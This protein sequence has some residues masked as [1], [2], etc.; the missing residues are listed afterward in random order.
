MEA[1]VNVDEIRSLVR[2]ND[3][4]YIEVRLEEGVASDITISGREIDSIS[5]GK[6]GGGNARV[7]I[8]GI[9]GFVY[10][11][12]LSELKEKIESAISQAKTLKGTVD[13][14]VDLAYVKPVEIVDTVNVKKDPDSLSFND[15]VDLLMHYS[16]VALSTDKK[17]VNTMISYREQKKN[18]YFAN[19]EGT[20]VQREMLDLSGFIIPMSS[21]GREI[22]RTLVTFGSNSDFSVA[23][24]LDTAVREKSL[25]AVKLLEAEVPKGGEFPV[26]ADN[27]LGGVFIHEA[28]GHLSEGDFLAEDPKMREIMKIGNV[29]GSKILNVFDTGDIDGHRGTLFYDDEGVPTKKVYLIKEGVLSSHLHSR[30]TAAK[31]KEEATG[32]GR[33]VSYRFPPIPRMR[34]TCID[35]GKD[36]VEDFVKDVKYGVYAKG[37]F[38]GQ[39]NGEQFTFVSEYAYL[40]EDGK[41]SKLLKNVSLSGNVFETL[42][43]IVGIADDYKVLDTGGGCGKGEQNP[44]PVSDGSPHLLISKAIIGGK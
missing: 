13:E 35:N 44:L 33:A 8:S 25:L 10:F 19:S 26:I 17:V 18:I 28:F 24:N 6:I 39:T 40:I 43:N 16:E 36:R 7:L 31:M 2:R 23:E 42:K 1:D 4:D 21:D 9:W 15:I 32:N 3:V 30:E 11:N 14:K 37:S 12:D 41:I 5:R 27:P 38:G 22:Q 34:I 20:Y 29:F